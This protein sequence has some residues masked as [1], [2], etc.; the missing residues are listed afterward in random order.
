MK[1][2]INLLKSKITKGQEWVIDNLVCLAKT[3]SR[4]YGTNIIG[5]DLDYTGVT[6]APLRYW[7]GL[8]KFEQFEFKDEKL[9][10]ECTI[11]DIRKYL[12]LAFDNNPN[13]IELLFVPQ[14]YRL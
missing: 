4:L 12:K 14:I 11:Y 8:P 3:G 2:I 5:S 1:P 13:I 6:I 9:G 7:V 10:I